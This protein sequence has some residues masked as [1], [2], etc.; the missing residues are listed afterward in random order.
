MSVQRDAAARR[1]RINDTVGLQLDAMCLTELRCWSLAD[2][3]RNLDSVAAAVTSGHH[4]GLYDRL[5]PLSDPTLFNEF[6]F[7]AG[8]H[9]RGRPRAASVAGIARV[10][11][12]R[13]L[14]SST[15]HTTARA[16]R[17]S[18]QPAEKYS[19]RLALPMGTAATGQAVP[20]S[21][22]RS[23]RIRRGAVG[24]TACLGIEDGTSRYRGRVAG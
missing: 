22:R 21:W 2:R 13:D 20:Q 16:A 14:I 7:N 4:V 23:R 24:K 3:A 12:R 8:Q 6:D 10:T 1:I 9:R 11:T 5:S 19:A 18:R 15:L 17:Y